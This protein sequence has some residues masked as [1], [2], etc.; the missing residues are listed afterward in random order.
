MKEPIRK[1][2]RPVRPALPGGKALA[3]LNQF[4][5]E[6]G[7]EV[8][9][10][11]KPAALPRKK[12]SAAAARSLAKK[13]GNAAHAYLAAFEQK[14]KLVRLAPAMP[15]QQGW[16]PLGPFAV[17][18]GQTYGS[19]PGSRP[20]I[21][22]RVSAIAVDP[23][24]PA[25]ILVGSAGGGVWESRDA[26]NSWAPR[27]DAQ[28]SLATGA[29][30][31]GPAN[32]MIVYAGTG[33]GNFFAR[34]GA[35]LLR[36][37]DGGTTWAM[38]ATSPFV[39]LGFY[40]LLV[41][42]LD[43]NHLLAATSGGLYE[44]TNGG[45]AWTQR[46][47]ARTWDL[48]MHPAVAGDPNST[49][50]VFAAC[51][52]GL[53][54][55]TNG[56]STWTAVSLPGAPATF[57]RIAVCHA[58]SDG[59]VVCVFA[60]SGA[61]TYLWRRN[62]FAGAFSSATPPTG[63]NTQ[64]AWYD[65]YAAFAPNDSD[66]LYLGAIDA[67][68]GTRSP[69]DVWTWTV[70][71]AKSSGDSIH[72]D[73]HAIAFSPTDPNTVYAGSD[74]GI[75]VSPDAGISWR[76]LNKDLC[77][78][79]FEYLAEHPQFDA[80]LLG[81]TQDN[82]TL[83]YEGEEVWYHVQDGDGG[84]CGVNDASP[85]TCYHTFFGMGME[86]STTGGG[87]GSFTWIG[88][89]PP[90]GHSSLFYPPL[91]VNGSLVV[92][93]GS[94]VFISTNAGNS[95]TSVA[96]PASVASALAAPTTSRIYVGTIAGDV[97]R[98]DFSGGSWQAPV[99]LTRPR[100]GFVSDFLV[101]P[102]NPNRLWATYSTLAGGHVFRSDD[103]GATWNDV[104]AGLPSIPVNAI[105]IDPI[106]PD[107]IWVA[108]DVGVYRT[109]D[110]GATWA[111]FSNL[112]PNALAKDLLLHPATRLL[113]VAL[114]SRGV[115]ETNVDQATMS[116][117]ELYVRDSDVD[118]GR[119]TPSPSG[120]ND[121]FNFGSLTHWWECADVKVD[122]PSYQTPLLSDVDFEFF[123]DDHGVFS[124][125]LTHEN[126]QRN[127]I[128]RVFVEL[129][130]RGLNP[131]TSVAAR[132]FF[133]DA[134]IGLPDLPTG[135]WTNFPNNTVPITSPWQPIAPHKIVPI[136]PVGIAQVVGFEWN[137]PATAASHSCLLVVTSAANDSISTTELNVP[138]LVLNNKKCGLK[139]LAVVD[140]PPIIGPRVKVL[141]LNLWGSRRFGRYALGIDRP[142]G[143]M[144]RAV[145]FSKRLSKLAQRAELEKA[146]LDSRDKEEL[147]KFVNRNPEL[148]T[149]LDPIPYRPRRSGVWI[150]S[151]EL[152]PKIPDVV[153]V[154]TERQ[155]GRGHWSF[156]LWSEDGTEIGGFTLQTNQVEQARGAIQ[157]LERRAFYD[158]EAER[159]KARGVAASAAAAGGV[160]GHR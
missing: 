157:F 143:S 19:G 48:S 81:G 68:K 136:V 122:S 28:P 73:Q 124:S 100:A 156:V 95:W 74:G 5:T 46:R 154:L 3:R 40:D 130:N 47:A 56:G 97:F 16:R 91:E 24:N 105:E 121:P 72:P 140:P 99:Q 79:E 147:L 87:W 50:E 80:W 138:T 142:A 10:I 61:N 7:F 4:E 96:L 98:I 101:D 103:G 153:V 117:V 38:L 135:F 63:L 14:Q 107:T 158:F 45:T 60:A 90:P 150:K 112:L 126:T 75:Y 82:G 110:A 92:Q 141:K 1:R 85:F 31:F 11:K 151:F 88:P 22:G 32:P 71:S 26:G 41:D 115:W 51:A 125:G 37:A 119:R 64:Q 8:T 66:V 108:A 17:P 111:S 33:E 113:R 116:D 25:H 13:D 2:V 65:W 144:V 69:M 54:R 114:Q 84:D 78:T 57:S 20:G 67:Y 35:G 52:D 43:S 104:S 94:S 86:R 131:A 36:S 132:V 27:T 23:G 18:H 76:S 109:T 15:I 44:S 29:I 133:A 160:F 62:L 42:P 146:K 118:T 159:A 134:S 49:K 59:N 12:G 53:F 9:N 58:P 120:V 39:G 21:A 145:F 137:V 139:N 149:I 148:R 127:R 55:S 30:A 77:I 155:L 6:R 152:D 129:H 93:A 89:N 70:I 34:L 123:E 102:T 106:N 83:R 128:V